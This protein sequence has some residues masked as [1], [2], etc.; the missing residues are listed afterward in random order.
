MA[1]I[2][3]AAP[4]QLGSIPYLLPGVLNGFLGRLSS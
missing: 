3:S 1:A 4:G 2:G